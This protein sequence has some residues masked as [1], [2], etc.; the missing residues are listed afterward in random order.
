MNA[1]LDAKRQKIIYTVFSKNGHVFFKTTEQSRK[2]EACNLAELQSVMGGSRDALRGGSRGLG[3]DRG[4]GGTRSQ[5]GGLRLDSGGVRSGN[6]GE[7]IATG[8]R[9]SR[10]ETRGDRTGD[11]QAAGAPASAPPPLHRPQSGHRR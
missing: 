5:P 1:L 4:R 7:N 3:R 2:Q 6:D 10:N 8:A 9:L 11:S